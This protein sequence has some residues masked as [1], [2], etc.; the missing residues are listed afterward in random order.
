MLM[1]ARVIICSFFFG[2]SNNT[3]SNIVWAGQCSFG[4]AHI[5]SN[6]RPIYNV[7]LREDAKINKPFHFFSFG[8]KSTKPGFYCDCSSDES[9]LP[10]AVAAAMEVSY[11]SATCAVGESP[12]PMIP[13]LSAQS[14]S[15]VSSRNILPILTTLTLTLQCDSTRTP[16]PIPTSPF[17]PSFSLSCYPPLL[18]APSSTSK[19]LASSPILSNPGPD[20]NLTCSTPSSSFRTT[21]RAFAPTVPTFNS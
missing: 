10:P 5:L 4:Q 8:R 3:C 7:R 1:M 14:A 9:C 21:S 15:K 12:A 19:T 20:P 6:L 17:I 11:S 18:R 13:N 16:L 2:S